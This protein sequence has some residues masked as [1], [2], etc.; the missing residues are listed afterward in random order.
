MSLQSY[1]SIKTKNY[2]NRE[3]MILFGENYSHI[4]LISLKDDRNLYILSIF[5][6]VKA[7]KVILKL[8]FLLYLAERP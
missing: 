7:S 5:S 8:K 4:F 6:S 3:N 2:C 1:G